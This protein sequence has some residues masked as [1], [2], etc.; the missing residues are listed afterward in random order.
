MDIQNVLNILA[1]K[2]YISEEI[3]PKILKKM[4]FKKKCGRKK[5]TSEERKGVYEQ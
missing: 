2:G 1:S 3:I 4:T 5:K